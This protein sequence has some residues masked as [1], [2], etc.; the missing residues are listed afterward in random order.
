MLCQRGQFDVVV[1][2]N[3]HA[4]ALAQLHHDVEKVHAV[5]LELLAQRHVVL[6]V[7]QD[8][9]RSDVAQNIEN[10][11][12]RSPQESCRAISDNVHASRQIAS[13]RRLNRFITTEL[14]PSMPNELF[15]M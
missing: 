7:A 15:K 10:D 3:L 4:I 1:F 14:M 11:C 2:G 6:Q 9:R 5:E 13:N 8:L 12:L